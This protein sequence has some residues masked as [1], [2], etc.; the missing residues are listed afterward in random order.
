[1]NKYKIGDIVYTTHNDEIHSCIVVGIHCEYIKNSSVSIP[2]GVI[3]TSTIMY[4]LVTIVR[5][6]NG[7]YQTDILYGEHMKTEDSI[8]PTKDDAIK[9]IK[10]IDNA[11]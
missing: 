6:S 8:Y 9:H 11:I 4:K 3:K 5:N 1:M 2:N 10:V 7:T